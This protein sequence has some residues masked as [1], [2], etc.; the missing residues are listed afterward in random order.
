MAF[1]FSNHHYAS[2]PPLERSSSRGRRPHHDH[3]PGILGGR[4]RSRSPSYSREG[5]QR[6]RQYRER[7]YDD[8]DDA[9]N[10]SPQDRHSSADSNSDT[11]DESLDSQERSSEERRNPSERREKSNHKF[12]KTTNVKLRELRT[13]MADHPDW[14]AA[15][16]ASKET[17]EELM[18][19]IPAPREYRL[20]RFLDETGREDIPRTTLELLLDCK[21]WHVVNEAA[22]VDD[23]WE[24]AELHDEHWREQNMQPDGVKIPDYDPADVETMKDVMWYIRQTREPN[25]RE[26]QTFTNPRGIWADILREKAK[27][28]SARNA[29]KSRRGGGR[30]KKTAG[31]G[32][33]AQDGGNS[34][35]A[36][37]HTTA[38]NPATDAQ[39]N[40]DDATGAQ[41]IED[42]VA[43]IA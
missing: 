11:R 2:R 25:D 7:S 1:R 19:N 40:E 6:A 4:Q 15:L 38:Q 3:R 13:W 22:A 39:A 31:G 36:G 43:T 12:R 14:Q 27:S 34:A 5:H 17:S 16:K 41:E 29:R 10:D 42:Y 23:F 28:A 18:L 37:G 32:W 21:L 20:L 9:S 24:G 8:T 33:Y 35:Q 30:G 26:P